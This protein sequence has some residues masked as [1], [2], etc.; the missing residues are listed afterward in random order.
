M[1]FSL[2]PSGAESERNVSTEGFIHS[3]LRNRLSPEKVGKLNAINT[4]A[5]A[6]RN[7]EYVIVVDDITDPDS[8]DSDSEPATQFENSA[9]T[10]N[11]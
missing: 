9:R 8:I 6:F 7:Y 10:R 5:N 2:V 3:K 1:Q 4:K 11:P